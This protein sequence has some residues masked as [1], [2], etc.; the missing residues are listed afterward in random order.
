MTPNLPPLLEWLETLDLRAHPDVQERARLLLL[1]TV[2]CATAGLTKPEP[3]A[4][5]ERPSS[6]TPGGCGWPGHRAQ[7]AGVDSAFVGQLIEFLLQG[8]LTARF[9]L[10]ARHGP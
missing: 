4:L 9:H 3:S 6:L 1:D 7:L 8:D 10:E 5:A 2:A